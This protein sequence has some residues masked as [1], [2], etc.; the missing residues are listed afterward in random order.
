M[1]EQFQS[2]PINCEYVKK[3]PGLP[4][5]ALNYSP[6]HKNLYCQQTAAANIRIVQTSE[7]LKVPI[8]AQA[9]YIFRS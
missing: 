5:P 3:I 2:G 4:Q 1:L 9:A 8:G 6:E 7:N